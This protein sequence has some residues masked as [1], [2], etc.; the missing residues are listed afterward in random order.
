V[1]ALVSVAITAALAA[2]FLPT[3]SKSTGVAEA[4]RFLDQ[5]PR[6]PDVQEGDVVHIK[7]E[8]YFR[9][10]P[11]AAVIAANSGIPTETIVTESWQEIGPDK[12]IVRSYA[13]TSDGDGNLIQ[14]DVLKPGV[15]RAVDPRTGRVV[16]VKPYQALQLEGAQSRAAEYEAALADGRARVVSRSDT[17]L[18]VE[19]KEAIPRQILA[20]QNELVDGDSRPY[21]WDLN[22]RSTINRVTFRADGVVVATEQY[23]VT[24]SGKEVLV[25]SS[26]TTQYEILDKFPE[27]IP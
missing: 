16:I 8:R 20:R 18:V 13:K 9:Y 27:G 11:K 25:F 10:G 21:F 15:W 17:E 19:V 3:G 4:L 26:R 24:A 6:L 12:T 2:T 7:I 22:P 14:E 5:V 1:A 23:V